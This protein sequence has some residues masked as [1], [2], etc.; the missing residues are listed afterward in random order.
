MTK[1]L[2]YV[3]D[4]NKNQLSPTN[5]VNGYRL[6]RKKKAKVVSKLP[7]VV[8]L[9]REQ[10]NTDNS[11]NTCGLDVGSLYTGI[12]VVSDCEGKNKVLFKGTIH[13]RKDVSKL[14]EQRKGYR[15]YR[16]FHKRYRKAR[17]NNRASSRRN[18]RIPP[19]IKTHKDEIL[20][21]ISKLSKWIEIDK[22]IIEDVAIDIRR[23][24]EGKKLYSWQ[25]QKSNRLDENLRK[26]VIIRD[27][28]TCQMCGCKNTLM[29]AHHITPRKYKGADTLYNLITLC[30]KC[31]KKAT[32]KEMEYS[33]ILYAKINGKNIRF[34]YS[35]RCMQGKTYLR[36]E[37]E[38]EY[39]VELTYGSDTANKRIDWNIKKSH[40]NDAICI[41]GLQ[42]TQNDC[43]IKDWYI[44]PL[45]SKN[46][47]SNVSIFHI[48]HRDI[49]KY[50]KKNG[51]SY[52]G[53]VT[54][55]DNIKKSCNFSDVENKQYKRYGIKSCKLLQRNKSI[56]FI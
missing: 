18:G 27:N 43:D 23:L 10:E 37:L 39:I 33:K 30:K 2:C 54:S 4:I 41:C 17:F 29:E 6:I 22:V 1:E 35:Q 5:Y 11:V 40:G 15:K 55:I 46:K 28:N 21:V 52:I 56:N 7:F 14:M 20:R 42:V 19:S 48:K 53:Y 38:K 47:I 9:L 8:Q 25:Y 32:G 31:H 34:D 12:S 16:R 24:T 3:I 44:R 13:H 26:A 49:I 51:E 45:R 50:T 36:S